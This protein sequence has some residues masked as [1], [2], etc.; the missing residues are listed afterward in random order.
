MRTLDREN[1]IMRS[2]E[3]ELEF[4]N[5]DLEAKIEYE[6]FEQE[7]AKRYAEEQD[8]RVAEYE[9]LKAERDAK[10]EA[11]RKEAEVR[12]IEREKELE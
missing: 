12:Q 8:A 4:R 3:M 10:I 7:K 11:D 9:K 6:K 1:E 5:K 2:R